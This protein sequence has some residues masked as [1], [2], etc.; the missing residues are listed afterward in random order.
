MRDKGNPSRCFVC[1]SPWFMKNCPHAT[2]SFLWSFCTLEQ[3]F[4]TSNH[5]INNIQGNTYGSKWKITL[6]TTEMFR[7]PIFVH[8]PHATNKT[9]VMELQ[10]IK[11]PQ[12]Q[13][14]STAIFQWVIHMCCI[15]GFCAKYWLL[16]DWKHDT[17]NICRA[18]TTEFSEW[19]M[20]D[21]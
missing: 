6:K 10:K 16:A 14:W 17:E 12:N 7:K 5:C 2:I 3:V 18:G 21:L 13:F 19:G 8:C 1:V 15:T 11:M 20:G 9:N 4:H